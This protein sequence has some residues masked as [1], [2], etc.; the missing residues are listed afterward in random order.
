MTPSSYIL[1]DPK[2]CANLRHSK[3]GQFLDEDD[4]YS[5]FSFDLQCSCIA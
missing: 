2:G 3:Q 5:A 1:A 4:I